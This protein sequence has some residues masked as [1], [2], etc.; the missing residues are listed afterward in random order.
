MTRYDET[1]LRHFWELD[2]IEYMMS[3]GHHEDVAVKKWEPAR[4]GAL[5]PWIPG[6]KEGKPCV[7]RLCAGD[8]MD[9]HGVSSSRSIQTS[10]KRKSK[11]LL[12]LPVHVL[13]DS[14]V[15]AL[16]PASMPEAEVSHL[17]ELRS[18]LGGS[19]GVGS[20]REFATPPPKRRSEMPQSFKHSD[21]AVPS[22][23]PVAGER[24]LG[25]RLAPRAGLTGSIRLN[26][27]QAVSAGDSEQAPSAV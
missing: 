17:E 11:K 3:L 26:A 2:F 20:A 12:A 25:D 24:R 18:S 7:S 13:P 5:P 15:G 16:L 1:R 27:K 22:E 23:A 14:E 21:V 8:T 19:R 6:N 9:T 4:K 10:W